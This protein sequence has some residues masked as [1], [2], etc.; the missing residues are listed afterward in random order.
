MG[1]DL[2]RKGEKWDYL[3][4]QI[5]AT[6]TEAVHNSRW[7]L[8]EGYWNIGKLI[9][10]EVNPKEGK[11]TTQL[12]TDL[13]VVVNLS[14]RTL[15]RALACFD[16]YPDIQQIPEGKNISWHKLITKYLPE[17]TKPEREPKVTIRK[18]SECGGYYIVPDDQFCTCRYAAIENG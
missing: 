18:C 1:T 12:L 9:R 15:W 8:I 14:K 5:N 2:I 10:E 4:E 17:T 13:S 11:F 6:I 7:F 3:V 16:K